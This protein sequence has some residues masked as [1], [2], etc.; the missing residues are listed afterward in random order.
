M[1][2]EFAHRLQQLPDA[3]KKLLALIARQ[4]QHGALRSKDPGTATMPELHESC[5]LDVEA[6]YSQLQVLCGAGL[7]TVTGEYPFEEIRL[8]GIAEA[9]MAEPPADLLE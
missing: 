5:G 1:D 8:T 3:A 2:T 7:I 9:A 4:A 6:M